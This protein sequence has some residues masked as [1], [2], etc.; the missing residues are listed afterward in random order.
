MSEEKCKHCDTGPVSVVTNPDGFSYF[1]CHEC[2]STFSPFEWGVY[3][4]EKKM[5]KK[6]L[7]SSFIV[8]PESFWK[9]KYLK[10]VEEHE[11]VK[12]TVRHQSQIIKNAFICDE[13]KC[14]ITLEEKHEH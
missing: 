6:E 12:A 7:L 3:R 2:D 9:N 14:N 1:Q 5:E 11:R 4:E 10:L 13:C 8:N